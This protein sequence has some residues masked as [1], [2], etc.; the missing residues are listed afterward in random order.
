MSLSNKYFSAV[1]I[2]IELIFWRLHNSI[3][4]VVFVDI[5]LSINILYSIYSS[6]RSFTAINQKVDIA[7]FRHFA[8]I[9]QAAI[10]KKC[11]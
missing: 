6:S 11:K 1:S 3:E 2:I 8:V 5:C 9:K 4:C 7:S 10:A